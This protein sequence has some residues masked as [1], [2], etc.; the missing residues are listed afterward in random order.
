M[1]KAV[2]FIKE[3]MYMFGVPNNITTDNGTQFM[4]R[5]FKDLCVDSGIKI[6][7]V[8]VSYPQSNGQVERSNDM[9]LQGSKPIIFDRLKPYPGK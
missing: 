5:E 6:N 2:D 9:I 8:S 4:A 7:Y 3:I 1:A